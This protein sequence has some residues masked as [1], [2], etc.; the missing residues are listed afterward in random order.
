MQFE[1]LD[2]RQ[3][4]VVTA[5]PEERLLVVAGPGTGKTQV[6]A[7]RLVQLINSGLAPS[8]ILV[9][10]FSRSAVRTLARRIERLASVGDLLIEELRYLSIRTFDSWT[11]R[12]LRQMGAQ[13][14]DLMRA[15]H[16]QNIQR[17]IDTLSG[18]TGPEAAERLSG[19]RH[20]IIDEFQDLP[21][22]RGTLVLSLLNLLAPPNRSGVGFTVLGDRAQAIYD[23]AERQGGGTPRDFWA[24]ILDLYGENMR[25]VVLDRNYRA[26]PEL[27]ALY[28]SLRITLNGPA[29]AAQKLEEI[30]RQVRLLDTSDLPLGPEWLGAAPKGSIAILTRT[31]G[32]AMNVAKKLSGTGTGGG[33]VAIRLHSVGNYAAVPAWIAA[34][35]A[36][37]RASVV[38][39]SQFLKIH[40]ANERRWGE[41]TCMA[42]SLPEADVAWLRLLRASGASDASTSLDM[43]DLRARLSWPDAFP[44]DAVPAADGV[45][46]ST[47]HQAKGMEFQNV[48][49]LESEPDEENAP[50][51]FPEEEAHIGFVAITRASR[52]LS[53]IPAG[54]IYRAPRNRG[55]GKGHRQRLFHRQG[56]WVYLAMG[57]N[58]DVNPTGFVDPALHGSVDAVAEVQTLLLEQATSLCGHKVILVKVALAPG[59]FIYNIH[60]Q[61]G[62]GPGRLLGCTDVQLTYDLLSVLDGKPMPGWIFNLRISDIVTVTGPEE[63]TALVPELYRVSRLWL[64]VTLFG[65]GDFQVTPKKK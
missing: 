3:S 65:T 61:A 17:L 55:F 14:G 28:A 47:V 34:L 35:L 11:F 50:D 22:V 9:L 26:V 5:A 53:R 58:G 60:L 51:E 25:R 45:L 59:R 15:S 29:D 52:H 64:G 63:A 16:E 46:I 62:R 57:I 49:I 27:A 48:V 1:A 18:A 10:S 41:D 13:P 24:L 21:G 31:N 12:L 8:E 30:R 37:L 23:F 39:K 7:L 6:S 54:Q 36:P 19:I 42:I 40:S 43:S 38:V 2:G 56:K 20:I 44:D 32:E 33:G 4:E